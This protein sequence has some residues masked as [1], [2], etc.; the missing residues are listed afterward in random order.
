MKLVRPF[1]VTEPSLVS[2]DVPETDA[3]VYNSATTYALNAEVI[4]QHNVYKSAQAGNLN[5]TPGAAGSE[6]WWSLQRP[7]NR[8]ALFDK[9]IGT[10]TA[11]ANSFTYTVQTSGRIDSA[12]LL[13]LS[14]T[15]VRIEVID[16]TDTVVYDETFNLV[17]T[18]GINNL[19]S[20]FYEPIRRRTALGVFNLPIF[21]SPK[22]R[23]TVSKPTDTAKCGAL[24]LG[25]QRTIGRT[26]YGSSV[27]ITDFSRKDTDDFGNFIIVERP[28]RR[29]GSFNVTVDNGFVDELQELL[30]AYRSIPIVYIGSDCFNAMLLYGFYKDFTIAVEN[31]GESL[32]NIDIESMT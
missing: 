1:I 9:K 25:Q 23:V 18:S 13:N 5:K 20:Y 21:L 3:P 24:I 7:T 30:E 31:F 29:R 28:F 19:Y 12:V 10:Q 2:S 14:A 15:S 17:S 8:W 22:I 16:E 6:G 11:Q 27:G 32:C 26:Q 4:Y